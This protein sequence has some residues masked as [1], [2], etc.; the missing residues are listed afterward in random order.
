MLRLRLCKSKQET[1]LRKK[2][3]KLAKVDVMCFVG[4]G[5]CSQLRHLRED[6]EHKTSTGMYAQGDHV[7]TRGD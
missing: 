3:R 4:E 2:E 5:G 6:F 1:R 7:Q